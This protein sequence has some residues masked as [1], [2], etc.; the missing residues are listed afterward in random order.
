M[1]AVLLMSMT[2]Q[3]PLTFLVF[4]LLALSLGLSYR[5]RWAKHSMSSQNQQILLVST[6][7]AMCSSSTDFIMLRN[8][9]WNG[10]G[11]KGHLGVSKQTTS[12]HLD[13]LLL[14]SKILSLFSKI[15]CKQEKILPIQNIAVLLSTWLLKTTAK[16][17]EKFPEQSKVC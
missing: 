17:F 6:N 14:F 15:E 10:W 8:L 3:H 4:G 2:K 5:K 9:W 11:W 16:H 13:V 7:P 1:A 12:S